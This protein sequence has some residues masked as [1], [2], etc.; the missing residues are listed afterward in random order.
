[1]SFLRASALAFLV[2]IAAGAAVSTSA[3][4]SEA[5]V[6][7]AILLD[8]LVRDTTSVDV[9]TPI[10]AHA[11][12][13]DGRICTYTRVHVDR[14]I[15]GALGAG[16]EEWVRT[17]GGVVG[18]V[19]QM[20]EGEPVLTVGRPSMLFMREGPPGALVV[21]A[22]AQ[23]LRFVGHNRELSLRVARSAGVGTLLTASKPV[24]LFAP[25]A[26]PLET[27]FASSARVYA[28]EAIHNRLLDDVVVDL[29]S[30]WKRIHGTSNGK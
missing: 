14:P 20:V 1:M 12:W 5:S 23:G 9:V 27:R 8:D 7:I 28:S 21:T 2:P 22:R 25:S 17:L 26:E 6:S 4:E 16:R 10:E 15:A 11:V 30:A 3:R 24:K 18:K 29:A 19:G 13:E